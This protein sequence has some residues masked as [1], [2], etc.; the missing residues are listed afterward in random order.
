MGPIMA[1]FTGDGP[2]PP[3]IQPAEFELRGLVVPSAGV[4]L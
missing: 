1:R 3:A 2:P 4:W